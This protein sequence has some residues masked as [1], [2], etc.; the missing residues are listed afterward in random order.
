MFTL[1]IQNYKISPL[2]LIFLVK[3][4]Q[5]LTL[6]R[7]P[8]KQIFPNKLSGFGGKVEPGESLINSAKREFLEETGLTITDPILKGTFTIIIDNGYIN[9]LHLFVATKYSGK[10]IPNS[11]EGEISWMAINT[12]FDHPDRVDHIGYYLKQII[13]SQDLYTGFAIRTG[14]LSG[15]IISYQDNSS[16]FATR[17]K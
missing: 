17:H 5:V 3:N 1:D 14:G 9:V 15:P 4:Y 8:H 6:R 13:S 2:T 16:H 7:S 10:L 11:D 12:F